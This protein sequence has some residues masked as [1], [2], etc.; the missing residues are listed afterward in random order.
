MVMLQD[1]LT[2]NV[3][4]LA[5]IR[6]NAAGAQ[7]S[8]LYNIQHPARFVKEMACACRNNVSETQSQPFVPLRFD[9]DDCT[10]LD[11]LMVFLELSVCS[12]C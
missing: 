8:A 7:T 12:F 5:S 9:A 1:D 6:S 2:A 3:E 4:F 10:I 11:M